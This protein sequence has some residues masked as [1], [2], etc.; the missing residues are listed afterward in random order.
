MCIRLIARAAFLFAV[1]LTAAAPDAWAQARAGGP[2]QPAP[3]GAAVPTDY[4]IGSEDVL[5]V[6]FWR[7]MEMSG[8]VTVRPDGR[9]T[10]PLIGDVMAAGL[11]PE[12]LRLQIDKLASKFI[13]EPNV[14]VI[15]R[16]INS[17]KVFITGQVMMPGSYALIGP[18]TIMQLIAVA[19]GLTEFADQGSITL[20]RTMSG[21]SRSFKFNYKD[22]ARGRRLEQNIVLLPGD[23]VVVP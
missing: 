22:V 5:G 6:V 8:D 12:D 11:R 4:V 19:G 18:Y 16:T 3:A 14:S 13:T 7:E 15:V 21:E 1:V 20:M 10:L 2:A 17:R 9:I 23:T